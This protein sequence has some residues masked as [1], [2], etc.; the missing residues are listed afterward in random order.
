MKASFADGSKALVIALCAAAGTPQPVAAGAPIAPTARVRT[1]DIEHVAVDL[2]FDWPAR[3]ALAGA[4]ITLAPLRATDTVNLD[5]GRL[6]IESVALADGTP[7]RFEYDG[8]DADD[9]LRIA[10]DRVYPAREPLTLRI[11]YRTTWIN[12]SDPN[13]LWG[14][15]GRGLRFHVPSSTEPNRRRQIWASGEPG[16]Q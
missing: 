12:H 5:A 2:R 16:S 15:N 8:S 9:A 1:V 13:N 3:Q 4:T 10:L 11:A 6:A 7:L 14:S